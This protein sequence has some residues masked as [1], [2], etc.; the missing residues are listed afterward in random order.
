MRDSEISEM[1]PTV[2]AWMDA[3]K[4]HKCDNKCMVSDNH[5]FLKMGFSCTGCA[6]WFGIRL[7]EWKTSIDDYAPGMTEL[8]LAFKTRAGRDALAQSFNEPRTGPKK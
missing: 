3:C 8:K 6:E 5:L 7:V 4:D 2:R 1:Y